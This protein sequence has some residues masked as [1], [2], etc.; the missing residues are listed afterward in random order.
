MARSL[1]IAGSWLTTTRDRSW[2]QP[3]TRQ[4]RSPIACAFYRDHHYDEEAR[5]R[6]FYGPADDKVVFWKLLATT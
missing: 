4:S 5:I 3:T 1:S 2:R 6:Q